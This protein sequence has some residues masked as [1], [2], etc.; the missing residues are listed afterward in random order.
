MTMFTQSP[1]TS[2]E[3]SQYRSFTDFDIKLDGIY[4]DICQG[5][6]INYEVKQI[7]I[8]KSFRFL[9][10]FGNGME[11]SDEIIYIV[12]RKIFSIFFATEFL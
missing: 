2:Y 1:S 10:F 7:L 5:L 12:F 11:F 8:W 3:Y 6:L 9:G 4:T